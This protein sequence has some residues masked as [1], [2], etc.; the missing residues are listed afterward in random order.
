MRKDKKFKIW[1]TKTFY[2]MVAV[3]I[4]GYFGLMK[5]PEP[6]SQSQFFKGLEKG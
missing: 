3:V 5:T 2:I 4:F 1:K 6:I